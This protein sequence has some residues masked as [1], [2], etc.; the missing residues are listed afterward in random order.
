MTEPARGTGAL[1]ALL[2]ERLKAWPAAA[3]IG[4]FDASA[5]LGLGGD[6][7]RVY[8][9]ASVTKTLSAYCCL[10]AVEEGSVGLDDPLGPPGSTLRHVLAH[11]SG[12]A[13]L[14]PPLAAPG[15]RRIY[16]NANFDL[17][18][19]HLSLA[20]GMTFAEYLR[21]GVLDPLGMQQTTFSGSPA[22]GCR[23]PLLDLIRWGQ[24]LISP[25]LIDPDTLRMAT[26][27]AFPGIPGVL[28]GFGRQEHN[29]WGLG[30]EIRGSKAPHWTGQHNSPAT[31]GHFGRSGSFLWIDPALGVGGAELSQE[32]FGEWA[33]TLWA[34]TN[35]AIVHSLEARPN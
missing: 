8:P 30:F 12:L 11:A 28:P 17:I 35:D 15:R 10:L 23:G 27:V 29:D 1:D 21:S 33:A 5:I 20:T 16:S 22:S 13:E 2:Q 26:T 14:A 24:E 31:F 19:R 18:G 7:T 34:D 6:P 9:W 3:S 32:P 25:T 4:V